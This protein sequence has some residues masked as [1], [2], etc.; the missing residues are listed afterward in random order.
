MLCLYVVVY[1][2]M[3]LCEHH[4]AE[5]REPHSCLPPEQKHAHDHGTPLV[6]SL[7]SMSP[8]QAG[9]SSDGGKTF[10][11][12]VIPTVAEAGACAC[13]GF[14]ILVWLNCY[15]LHACIAAAMD[16]LARMCL[17]VVLCNSPV[18]SP[19]AQARY[20]TA[21][22]VDPDEFRRSWTRGSRRRVR[23]RCPHTFLV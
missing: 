21:A 16:M 7:P 4:S 15:A 19:H 6:K 17:V 2:D 18:L 22:E 3:G 11:L 14:G 8:L 1:A 23:F 5:S 9:V 12:N 10:Q 13:M 20:P